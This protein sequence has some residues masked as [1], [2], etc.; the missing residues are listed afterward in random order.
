MHHY[1]QLAG[2]LYGQEFSLRTPP[3]PPTSVCFPPVSHGTA[4][5]SEHTFVSEDTHGS[6][7]FKLK[8]RSDLINR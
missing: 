3:H 5:M 7:F 6:C 2:F 8:K 4:E 1:S